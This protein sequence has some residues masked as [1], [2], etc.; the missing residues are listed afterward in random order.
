MNAHSFIAHVETHHPSLRVSIKLC[1]VF[2]VVTLP[3]LAKQGAEQNK[4]NT[5][6]TS[7]SIKLAKKVL[8]NDKN[9]Q[10]SSFS[11]FGDPHK[12]LCRLKPRE[13]DGKTRT[14]ID[15]DA[16]HR[17]TAG[18]HYSARQHNQCGQMETAGGRDGD[19]LPAFP[20]L[21]PPPLK[22]ILSMSSFI[23]NL[24]K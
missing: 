14:R 19:Q 6:L 13:R 2:L 15:T 17:S 23:S 24:S 11:T 9:L 16:D 20:S 10:I 21:S 3:S 4:K 7:N 12:L 8:G 1:K 22:R 5:A 18:R